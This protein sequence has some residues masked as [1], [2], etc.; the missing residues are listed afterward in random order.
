MKKKIGALLLAGAMMLSV[1]TGCGGSGNSGNSDAVADDM[2]KEVSLKWI[3]AADGEPDGYDEVIAEVNKYLKEKINATLEM[4]FIQSGDFA[5]KANM[6]LASQEDGWDLMFTSSWQNPYEDN[7]EKGGYYDIKDLLKSETPDLYEFFP[8]SYWEALTMNDGG[9]YA[10]PMNQV[11][12][13]QKGLWFKEELVN[14]YDLKDQIDSAKSLDDLT[15]VYETIAE[16]ESDI[17]PLAFSIPDIFRESVT[18]VAAGFSI[19]DGEVTDMLDDQ[20]LENFKITRDWYEKKILPQDTAFDSVTYIKLGKVFSRYNRQLPGIN[21]KHRIAYDWD[22]Y[23]VATTG[24]ILRR[25]DVQGA[26]TAVNCN[27]KNPARALKLLELMTTDEYLFNLMAYGIEGVNYT[28]DG[29]RITPTENSYY[30]QEFRIGNQ[31]LAYLMPGYE[32][33][34][35]EETDKGNREAPVD[36]NIGFIFDKSPIETEISNVSSVTEY[37]SILGAGT[38]ADVEGTFQKHIEKRKVAGAQ[39]VKEEIERQYEEW[40]ASQN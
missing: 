11:M 23:N 5:T 28:K 31:F 34:V 40:K 27:S 24:T 15:P 8:E 35:W 37:S 39:T 6:M 17:V 3:I 36:E 33:G 20:A 18:T 25:E 12:Y 2:S 16:N 38:A 22:A 26:L 13:Q 1:L 19:V 30:V 7:A 4:E 32:E 9:I 10:V 29:N 14:K 21:V